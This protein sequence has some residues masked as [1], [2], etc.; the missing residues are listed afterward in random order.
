MLGS[1]VLGGPGDEV[2]GG[3]ELLEDEGIEEGAGLGGVEG[4]VETGG[5]VLV[6]ELDEVCGAVVEFGS[7]AGGLFFGGQP[8]EVVT[9]EMCSPGVVPHNDDGG[10]VPLALLLKLL[11]NMGEVAVSEGE[12]V[13]V[14]GV[15]EGELG[16]VAVVDTYTVGDGEVKKDETEGGVAE[17][18]IGVGGDVLKVGEV[19]S[20]VEYVFGDKVVG[21]GELMEGV[22]ESVGQVDGDGIEGS[23]GKETH[24]A[25]D[26]IGPV[27][28][29][30]DSGEDAT[31]GVVPAGDCGA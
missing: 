29:V 7:V 3:A 8:A 28:A 20:G 31:V 5:L 4:G 22:K 1:G 25:W 2:V 11:V 26:A 14:G 23:V 9:Y 19:S 10:R 6:G 12:V 30:E 18:L 16:G 13:E 17:E 27:A 24:E 21:V 15:G